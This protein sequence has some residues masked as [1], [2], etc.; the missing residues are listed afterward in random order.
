M[1]RWWSN[2]DLQWLVQNYSNVG[3]VE[4]SKYL[5]RSQS[6]ILH[7]ACRMGLKRKGAGRTDRFL[8]YDGYIY[9][10]KVNERYALH[11]KIMEDHIGRKL[12]PD[13][14]VHHKNGDRMDNRLDNLELTTRSEHQ[15]ILHK[16][17]LEQRRNKVNGRFESYNKFEI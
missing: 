11:R 12:T 14:V 2:E 1:Y 6:S 8:I 9:V 13:E 4:C 15:K 16:N 7:K 3:L 17:D 5:N 10:S